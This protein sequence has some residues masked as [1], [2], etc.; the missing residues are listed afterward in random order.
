MNHLKIGIV[1]GG[2]AGSA[3]AHFLS[4]QGHDITVFEKKA[5]PQ[6]IGS[7]IMLQPSGLKVFKLLGLENVVFDNASSICSFVG[8]NAI[9][10]KVIDI[11]FRMLNASISCYG[12]HRGLLFHSLVNSLKNLKNITQINGANVT[13]INQIQALS[14]IKTE[15]GE[16][17]GFDLVLVTSGAASKLRDSFKV[18]KV[19]KQQQVSAIWA[20]LKYDKGEVKEG[21][22]TQFYDNG[23]LG[24]LMPIGKNPLD[25]SGK[26]IVNFFWGVNQKSNPIISESDFK[27]IKEK[28]YKSFKNYDHIID[29]IET[30]DQLTFSPY[31]DSKLGSYYEGN[32]AFL[33]DVAHAM[34]P[35]LSSGTNLAL[36]DAYEFSECIKSNNS[37]VEALKEY[38]R[39]RQKQAK[40]CQLVSKYVTPVFQ[41]DKDHSFIRDTLIQKIYE[42]PLTRNIMLRTLLGIQTGI[43]SSLDKRYYI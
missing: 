31:Y 37:I 21:Q 6:P 16:Y 4:R 30:R 35:Q 28:F 9:D 23:V 17:K 41:G 22:I 34:S 13:A 1:G 20:T 42:F 29:K 10:K 2:I 27:N 24:G 18:N 26:S 7:G 36:L 15:E 43:F 12:V 11:D 32:V 5:I 14:T 25:N 40:Y 8:S 33:G 38:S 19:S 39:K 3:A